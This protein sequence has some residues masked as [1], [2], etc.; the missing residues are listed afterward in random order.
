MIK[1]DYSNSFFLPDWSED[2]SNLLLKPMRWAFDYKLVD[3]AN[4]TMRDISINNKALKIFA[5]FVAFTVLLPFTMIGVLLSHCSASRARSLN[6]VLQFVQPNNEQTT[7]VVSQRRAQPTLEEQQP[8][9]TAV[10]D[11]VQR[12]KRPERPMPSACIHYLLSA[13]HPS[14]AAL[15]MTPEKSLAD[16]EKHKDNFETIRDYVEYAYHDMSFRK[17][18]DLDRVHQN[19]AAFAYAML[20]NGQ[21]KERVKLF[22]KEYQTSAD[23]KE[24]T[25]DTHKC[26]DMV[27]I[28]AKLVLVKYLNSQTVPPSPDFQAKMAVLNECFGDS[29]YAAARQIFKS[30]EDTTEFVPKHPYSK[31]GVLFCSFATLN[32]LNY[33]EFLSDQKHDYSNNQQYS[34]KIKQEFL[35]YGITLATLCHKLQ[36]PEV[37]RGLFQAWDCESRLDHYGFTRKFLECHA[38]DEDDIRALFVASWKNFSKPSD[39]NYD[40]LFLNIAAN[41]QYED[42]FY[43]AW[44]TL[45]QS[46]TPWKKI[47]A[48]SLRKNEH[49]GFNLNMLGVDRLGLRPRDLLKTREDQLTSALDPFLAKDPIGIVQQYVNINGEAELQSESPAKQEIDPPQDLE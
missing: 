18:L 45:I 40:K 30:E 1:F 26:F 35:D 38:D 15:D 20:E 14:L 36:L 22:T 42:H 11:V 44:D 41:I 8:S 9:Q 28:V 6:S 21:L 23:Y 10:A 4:R 43:L 29:V 32:G 13:E 17:P 34:Y 31:F 25:H 2:T 16:Y 48:E 24:R 46:K 33:R 7:P 5:G 12:K 39:D 37:V 3:V 27:P 47:F 49:A 19:F